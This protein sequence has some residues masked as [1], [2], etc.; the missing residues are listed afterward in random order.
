[1]GW[2]GISSALSMSMFVFLSLLGFR[3][4]SGSLEVLI[5]FGLLK[6]E[7]CSQ[8]ITLILLGLKV[9]D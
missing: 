8:L 3:T 6:E 9:E 7:K 1:L 2:I 5:Y 4:A